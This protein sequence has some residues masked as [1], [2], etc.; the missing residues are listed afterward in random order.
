L[1]VAAFLSVPTRPLPFWAIL[2]SLELPPPPG[3]LLPWLCGARFVREEGFR[4]LA[5]ELLLLLRTL[6][7]RCEARD[8]LADL[9]AVDRLDW[10]EA[11]GRR[12]DGLPPFDDPLRLLF[13]GPLARLADF[14]LSERSS[15][16]R[17]WAAAGLILVLPCSGFFARAG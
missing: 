16:E 14:F 5:A 2:L 8:G 4:E 3:L 11:R 10:A 17:R 6:D 12:A 9:A 1:L 15:D 7:E 13:E